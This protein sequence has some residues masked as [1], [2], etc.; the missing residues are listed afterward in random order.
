MPAIQLPLL[1]LHGT[2]DKAAK[3]EGSQYFMENAGSADKELKLYEGHY[4]DL[5]NDKYNGI[6]IKDIIRWLDER[7]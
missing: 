5:L 1:I 6:I 3:P 7:V 4:H 2:A